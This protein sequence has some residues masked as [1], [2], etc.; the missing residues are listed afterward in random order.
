MSDFI[1]DAKG[2]IQGFRI[3]DF[4]Y[5]VGGR[6]IGRVS[7][8][9][10][11]RLDGSYVG[12]MFRNMVVARPVGIRR[13]LPPIGRPADRKPPS[14]DASRGGDSAG[15]ADVFHRLIEEWPPPANS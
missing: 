5:A 7:A 1:F 12:E 4:L 11:Y 13:N 2:G 6:A 10:V 8:E 14:P 9:R 3:G 15:Y